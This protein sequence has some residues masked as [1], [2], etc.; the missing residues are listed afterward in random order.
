MVSFGFKHGI[1]LDGDLIFDVRFIPNPYYIPELWEYH[2]GDKPVKDYVL[3][4]P[5]TDIF[6]DKTIDMLEFLIPHYTVEGKTQLI[7]GIGCTGGRHRSV[8]IANR[9]GEVLKNNNHRVSV[10]H[11]DT[12]V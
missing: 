6:I 12:K 2:G 9:I 5:Q 7:V 8:A 10:D 11:R 3:K 4:W 1:L